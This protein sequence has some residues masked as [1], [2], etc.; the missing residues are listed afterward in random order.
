M[1]ADITFFVSSSI[2]REA[3]A[4][5]AEEAEDRGYSVSVSED[6]SADAEIGVYPQ[7]TTDLPSVNADLSL[8]MFH[9]LDMGYTT[10]RW[11][12]ENWSRF[13][14]GLL[15]CRISAETW[16]KESGHPQARPKI[17]AFVVGWPKSDPI[18]TT[19]Y[20]ERVEEY[21]GELDLD[22]GD[23]VLY[24]PTKECAG[25]IHDFFD[26]MTDVAENLVVKHAPYEYDE[27][28]RELYEPYRDRDD[29]YIADQD[30]EIMH[31]LSVADVVVSDESSVLQEAPLTDTVPVA[32]MDWP[33][34][35]PDRPR[36]YSQLP[37]YAVQAEKDSLG[38]TVSSVLESYDD[39]LQEYRELR[40]DIYPYLSNSSEA[41][42]DLVDSVVEG[43]ELSTEPLEPAESEYGVL[44]TAY[45]SMRTAMAKPY[46]YLRHTVVENISDENERRLKKLG[47]HKILY[48][49]DRIVGYNKYR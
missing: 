32:V 36:S 2:Y 35:Y 16:R 4:P 25:K 41:V 33:T 12:K 22:D 1:E 3:V 5:I 44:Q 42:M 38:D 27:E 10:N 26:G 28:I 45:Y 30:D 20:Q 9:G 21:R 24:A 19:E 18:F 13:D 49:V 34:K 11:P 46:H 15:P 17:G 6:L 43:E 31:C 14:V 37:D 40:E 29:V 23:T 39:R 47:L 8:T 7:H 48:I